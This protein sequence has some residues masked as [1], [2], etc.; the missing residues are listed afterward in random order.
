MTGTTWAW[1]VF[2]VTTT[3]G[4]SPCYGS[5]WRTWGIYYRRTD[6]VFCV[7]H[8]PSG[9]RVT[10]FDLLSHARRWCEAID[11][12]A[13]WEPEEPSVGREIQLELHRLAL[14]VAGTR[15]DLRVI[16]RKQAAL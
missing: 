2:P 5:T 16:G 4:R 7:C 1:V 8:L 14:Q 12:L 10:S 3:T 13:D 6:R 15:P 9:R 11:G